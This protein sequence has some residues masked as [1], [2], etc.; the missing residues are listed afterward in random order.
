MDQPSLHERKVIL[1]ET[2]NNFLEHRI[3]WEN[4]A[5]IERIK[6]EDL[7]TFLE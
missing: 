5:A 2:L 1:N 3:P 7:N 4:R 6:Q